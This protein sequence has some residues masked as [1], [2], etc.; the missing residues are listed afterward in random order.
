[1]FVLVTTQIWVVGF[2]ADLLSANRKL[3]SATRLSQRR[4]ELAESDADLQ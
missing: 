3:A 1:V 4:R 2:L